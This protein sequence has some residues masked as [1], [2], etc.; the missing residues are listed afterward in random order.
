LAAVRRT[1]YHRRVMERTPSSLVAPL[2]AK[3]AF[4]DHHCWRLVLVALLAW[5]AWMTLTLFGPDHPLQNLFSDEPI[6]SGKHPLHLYH[7]YL[8][9]RSFYKTGSL[10]CYDPNFQAGY[11]KT[12]IF[13]SASRPGELFLIL[14]GGYYRP[15]A[16]KLGLALCCLAVPLLI[17]FGAR[18]AGLS[19]GASSLATV[20]GMIV[21]WGKPCQQALEAGELDLLLAAIASVAQIGL[22]AA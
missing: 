9:A 5:Q 18:T 22:Q 2:S 17:T 6:V 12:P 4:W 13:D 21:W 20:L 16:Y 3:P 19:R 10:C 14:A 7:G 1:Y 8:G 15:M 11:P